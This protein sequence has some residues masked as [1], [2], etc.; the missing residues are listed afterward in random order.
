MHFARLAGILGLLVVACQDPDTQTQRPSRPEPVSAHHS[1][2][3]CPDPYIG[4]VGGADTPPE[5]THRVEPVLDG[6]ID[7]SISQRMVVV[8]AIIDRDGL[9]CAVR[10]LQ[11]VKPEVDQAVIAAVKQWRF[12]PAT[13][14]GRPV[15]VAYNISVPIR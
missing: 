1:Y 12:K 2:P 9:P 7:P 15:Q 6:F 5:L 4:R 10:L 13:L 11:P 3:E 8:E 14:R